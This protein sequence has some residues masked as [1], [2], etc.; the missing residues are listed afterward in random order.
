[1]LDNDEI[2]ELKWG[3]DTDD[4]EIVL[5]A[6][7][8]FML[9]ALKATCDLFKIDEEKTINNLHDKLKVLIENWRK[10]DK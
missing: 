3:P 9:V 2:K 1:M 6:N 7:I 10:Q 8:E 5:S 4:L